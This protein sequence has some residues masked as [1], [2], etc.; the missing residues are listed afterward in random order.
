MSEEP[1]RKRN[2]VSRDLIEA[3]IKQTE[4][5]TK[6]LI[7]INALSAQIEKLNETNSNLCAMFG[8]GL[9]KTI[10]DTA[11]NVEFIRGEFVNANGVMAAL[12]DSKD[13]IASIYEDMCTS[14]G[15]F[16]KLA[17]SVKYMWIPVIVGV[18]G[19]LGYGFY[20]QY[21]LSGIVEKLVVILS[22]LQTLVP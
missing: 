11:D 6:V 22:K 21:N 4:I 18:V 16:C 14:G 3:T 20:F 2:Y 5:Q 12:S 1:K 7:S 13:K 10:G 9:K 19:Y 15:Y 17:N 8:D